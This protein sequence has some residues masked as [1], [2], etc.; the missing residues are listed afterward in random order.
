MST[1]ASQRC[2]T[3][4]RDTPTLTAAELEAALAELG[5]G[6]EVVG[7]TLHRRTATRDFADAFALAVRI[8]FIA[9]RERHHP[10]LG[11]GW[12]YVDVVLTTHAAGGLTTNDPI[13][14]AKIE[15]L[16]TG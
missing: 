1:L 15:A 7:T 2:T 16:L 11:I 13:V 12:G 8:G 6:W 4:T 5:S 14:A 10:D 3:C 9:E